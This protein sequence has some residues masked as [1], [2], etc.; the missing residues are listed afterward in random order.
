MAREGIKKVWTDGCF[1]MFHYG[2]ANAL[3]QSKDLGDYLIAGVHSSSDINQEKG[4]P[5]ME[6]EERCEV[7][8]SCRYVDEVVKDAPFVTQAEMV[9]Q[10]EVDI[11]VHGDDIVL[12][13]N[14][15]DSYSQV[16]KLGMFKEV[17]R[18]L[19]IST[20]EIVGRMLL[21]SRGAYSTE[22]DRGMTDD[23]RSVNYR[24][25]FDMFKASMTAEKRGKVVFVDGNFDLFH[26]G[27]TTALR[28]ARE[29]GDY[30]MVGIHDDET[31][32]GYTRTGSVMNI[33]ERM[34]TLMS[35]R[36]VDEVLVSP[37]VINQEFVRKNG[38][39]VI[40]SSY[41][42]KDLSRY[43]NVK[44]MVKHS[45]VENRFTYLSAEHIVNRIILNY[46]KYAGRNKRKDGCY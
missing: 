6:D 41:D 11:V 2:H 43:D 31:T 26:A 8:R 36:Y 19:G 1:D 21:N 27:H 23:G 39:D 34:L 25:L 45:Y 30:L 15:I 38:I 46:Q 10:Y 18:T 40:G 37:Y 12:D 44:D 5:V 35:C 14:G 16:R 32:K 4:L 28:I 22:D 7:V 24:N 42:S 13:K 20:T 29:L 9:K 17:R 33:K 3:R